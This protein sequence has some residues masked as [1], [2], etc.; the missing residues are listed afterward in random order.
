MA[1]KSKAI[2]ARF[3][4]QHFKKELSENQAASL[5]LNS[6]TPRQNI[7]QGLSRMK[8]AHPRNSKENPQAVLKC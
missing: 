6:S 4:G 2:K 5:T 7:K 1:I 3:A 8:T